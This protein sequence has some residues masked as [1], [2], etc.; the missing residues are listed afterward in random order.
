MTKLIYIIIL[1]CSFSHA[2]VIRWP[3]PA[4][5]SSPP[6]IEAWTIGDDWS[7]TDGTVYKPSGVVSGDLLVIVVGI[8]E[9]GDGTILEA[10][11]GWTKEFEYG[12][13]ST[14]CRVAMYWKIATGSEGATETITRTTG[15]AGIGWY[16]RISGANSTPIHL[17][18]TEGQGTGTTLTASSITT[19]TDN[20]LV[21]AI[22][23][24]D[25]GDGF[26]FTVSGTGW[27]SSFDTNQT[28]NDGSCSGCWS[29]GW[30]SREVT[31]AG[32]SNN[33]DFEA[34]VSDGWETI[35]FA[36]SPE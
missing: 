26:P 12:D 30:T 14:D 16:L 29:G 10:L 32:A 15:G 35:Q 3:G 23:S 1:I 20:T 5:S 6:V 19:T 24:F 4:A 22:L 25:G 36:I 8:E 34:S 33:V 7:G 9:D 17:V 2:Q 28:E 27:P 11:S 31:T 21:I 18:G 13:D